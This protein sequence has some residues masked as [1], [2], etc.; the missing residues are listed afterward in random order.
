MP[1]SHQSK[2]LTRKYSSHILACS[3]HSL[4]T[5]MVGGS[6]DISV[7]L[8][9]R[10]E[11]EDSYGT[12]VSFFYPPGLSY[13]TV[14]GIQVTK[15]FSG[16]IWLLSW[17]P[18]LVVDILT[19]ASL[20]CQNQHSRRSWRVTCESSPSTKGPETLHSSTCSINHPL[21]PGNSEV[22]LRIPPHLFSFV[23]WV[24]FFF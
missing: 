3:P 16:S 2:L 21:F 19:F 5:L 10:N 18:C 13:R 9:V 24:L 11:G 6:Q 1:P 12:Q 4:D 20:A 15:F 14:S 7:M 22:R 23:F 17:S 8:T